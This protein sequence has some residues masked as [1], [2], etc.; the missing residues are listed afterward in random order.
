MLRYRPARPVGI[1]NS[2]AT[3]CFERITNRKRACDD[4]ENVFSPRRAERTADVRS[5]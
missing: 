3:A 4:E 1:T 2:I 5:T